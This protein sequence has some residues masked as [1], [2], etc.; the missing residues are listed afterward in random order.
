MYLFGY[1]HIYF[2]IKLLLEKYLKLQNSR[3]NVNVNFLIA[4][5]NI[6]IVCQCIGLSDSI[7]YLKF[8]VN[9]Y[10]YLHF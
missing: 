4:N 7:T 2:T 1:Q 5:M 10:M 6:I 3:R 9:A 8:K